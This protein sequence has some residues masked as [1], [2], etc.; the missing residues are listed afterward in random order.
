MSTPE[1]PKIAL[2]FYGLLRSIQYTLPN[3]QKQVFCAINDAGYEYDIYCHNYYFPA[4]HKYNN[5]RSR[6]YNIDLDPNAYKLLN[7]KY[8]ISD[9][10]LDVAEQLN[11]PS[12]R[13]CGDPWP[14]TGFKTLDNYL[15]AM[16]SRKKIT[17]LL[18]KNITSDPQNHTYTAVIFLRSDVLFEKPLPIPKLI[19]LLTETENTNNQKRA[20]LIPNFHH[21]LGGI[22]DRMFISKPALALEY[23]VAFDLLLALSKERKLHSEQINKY[24][25]QEVCKATPVLVPIF[26]ARVRANG[27]IL[28]ENYGATESY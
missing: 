14:K 25:I 5:P 26:F 21:W 24:I 8:Y 15:L 28:N 10:Q 16:Y 3:L 22:N 11:L 19:T 6:E 23:G 18:A 7:P 12:Y 27:N 20:C 1:K 9:N 13:T 4:N 2:V 17:E